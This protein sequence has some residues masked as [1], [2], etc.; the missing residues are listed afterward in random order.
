MNIS[1]N[2][3]KI[4]STLHNE[5]R[6]VSVSKNRSID[7]IDQAYKYGQRIFGENRV[8]ELTKKYEL[9]PKDIEW[10]MIGHLQKK[11]K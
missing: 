9:L 2:L 5:I 7:D 11:I 8:K 3:K 4:Y 6:L 1:E 10:H